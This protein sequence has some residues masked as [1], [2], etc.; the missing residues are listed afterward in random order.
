[1]NGNQVERGKQREI[2]Q[3]DQRIIKGFITGAPL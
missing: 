3:E 2:S 1:M